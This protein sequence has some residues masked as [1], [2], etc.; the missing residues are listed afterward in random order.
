MRSGHGDEIATSQGHGHGELRVS[1]ADREQVIEALKVAFVHE[2]LVK[3][4]FELRVG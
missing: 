3:D 4:E 2:R 1:H